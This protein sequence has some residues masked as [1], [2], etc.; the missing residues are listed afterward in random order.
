M[1]RPGILV[2][3]FLIFSGITVAQAQDFDRSFFYATMASGKIDDVN[4]QIE[5]LHTSTISEKEA[6][7]GALLMRKAGLVKKPVEK[8]NFFKKGRIK[9]ETVILTD[10]SIAEYRF[11]RLSIQE[12]APKIVKYATKI[13]ADRQCIIR[14][15]KDMS[16]VVQEAIIAYSRHS[17]I[18][19]PQDL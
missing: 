2:F 14:S 6:Y 13:E 11:L 16:P 17:K 3:L 4:K 15:F 7:E 8:L 9:L 18:L 10:S 5:L 1:M 12:H 19:H